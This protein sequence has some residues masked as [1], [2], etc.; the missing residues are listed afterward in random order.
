MGEGKLTNAGRDFLI[1]NLDPMHDL[2]LNELRGWP[3]LTTAASITL[4]IKQSTQISIPDGS[5]G[6]WDCIIQMNPILDLQ[7]VI[8]WSRVNDMMNSPNAAIHQDLAMVTCKSYAGS[9]AGGPYRLGDIPTRDD[10][11]P[12]PQA[13][14]SGNAR[15]IGLGVEVNNT[16]ADLY[17]QGT[18]TAYRYPQGDMDA[19]VRR[20]VVRASSDTPYYP[21]A[22]ST[23]A[24]TFQPGAISDAMLLPGTRQW[25]AA[26]GGYIVAGFND[27]QNLVLPAEYRQ[28]VLYPCSD[29]DIAGNDNTFILL[30]PDTVISEH[31]VEGN[32][33]PHRWAPINT[34]G[35]MFTGLSEQST[36]TVNVT[37]FLEIFPTPAQPD[38]C[39]L[40]KPSAEFD[41]L[42][43]AMVTRALESM[44][45]G[46]PASD[47]AFGDWFAGLV[48]DFAEPVGT[49]L[50][51]LVPGAQFMG[52]GAKFLADRYL[53][54]NAPMKPPRL[55]TGKQV[56]AQ[57][58]ANG[59]P[60]GTKDRPYPVSSRNLPKWWGNTNKARGT[61]K[62]H[63]GKHYKVVS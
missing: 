30:A 61:V 55:Q 25:P 52:A 57:K 13:Y 45:V 59:V 32:W 11:I 33:R 41:P 8:G 7:Q 6:L 58:K 9:A 22:A 34:G 63:N 60:E 20:F 17:K 27:E 39:V 49:A 40:A 14:C 21:L 29:D 3:D 16:T 42:A 46:V 2:Q 12:L 37:A 47:N 28:P 18:V 36:L 44:P 35:M 38:L 54:A 43:M 50:S 26:F 31:D 62:T 53:A 10:P 24:I 4:C 15:L 48:S 56:K 51:A 23:Q 19:K 5:T 1:A